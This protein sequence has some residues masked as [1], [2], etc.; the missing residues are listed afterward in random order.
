VDDSMEDI[1]EAVKNA[2]LIH[3]SAA[4]PA[5]PFRGCGRRGPPSVPRAAWRAGR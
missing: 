2:A 3:K 5:S 1:F 4:G